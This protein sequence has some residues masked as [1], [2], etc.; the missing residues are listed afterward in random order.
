MTAREFCSGGEQWQLD[1]N[2]RKGKRTAKCDFA[3]SGK[4]ARNGPESSSTSNSRFHPSYGASSMNCT[5][6]SRGYQAAQLCRV[7]LL[8]GSQDRN[9]GD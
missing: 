3:P 2:A 6:N 9:T 1:L 4:W 5:G 8:L 7:L